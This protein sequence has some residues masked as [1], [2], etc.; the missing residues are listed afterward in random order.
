MSVVD[1]TNNIVEIKNLSFSYNGH[2]VLRDI[3]LNIHRGDYLG[4]VGGNGAGKTTLLKLILGLLTP[5]SGT[6]RLFGQDIRSFKDWSKVGYVPQKATAFDANFPAT[7]EETV[8]MGRYGRRGLFRRVT[9]EDREKALEAI[10]QVDMLRYRHTLIGDLSGG[11]QQRVFIARALAGEPEV[12]FLDEPTVG[13]EQSIKEEFYA[14]LRK[15]NKEL[16]LTIVLVTHDVESMAHEAM[17]IACVDRT[18]FFHDSVDKYFKDTHNVI[19]P[20]A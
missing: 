15:L 12:M 20:H 13:I 4:L 19:H 5:K 18:I 14:L 6:I 1:H 9:A 7:V 3:N 11:E 17:H 2:E 16:E 8:L 10:R